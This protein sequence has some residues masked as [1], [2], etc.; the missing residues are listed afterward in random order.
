MNDLRLSVVVPVLQRGRG[1]RRRSSTGS[2][3]ASPCRA[4]CWRSTT[5]PTTRRSPSS[6]SAPATTRAWCPPSTPTARARRCA[7]RYGIDHAE[8]DDRRGH[9]GRRQRRPPAGRGP[10]PPGRAGR[11]GRRRVALRQGRPAGRRPVAEADHVPRRRA[12]P[13]LVRPGRHPRRDQLVQG[14]RPRLRA[15]RWAS[16]PTPASSSGSRWWP[17]PG[18]TACRWPSCRRSGSTARSAPSNFQVWSW[19]PR[20]LRWYRYAFGPRL[21]MKVLVSGSSGF[22]GGYVVQELLVA[23][24][25]GGRHRRPLQVRQGRQVLRRRPRL[26]AGRGRRPR[27]RADDRAA[28]RLRPLHRRRG[29][30]R[31]DLVL[32]RLRL[33]PARQQRADHGR[34]VR[35]R[36]QGRRGAGGSRRSPT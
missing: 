7:L 2:S 1:D 3:T 8:A 33:R 9:D 30:D 20:Y 10:G 23:R 14:L 35:R 19:L 25:R 32:P 34:V 4:R 27:R 24:P 16:S 5:R 31:R 36:D 28:R 13:L 15:A 21:S 12:L 18:G 29:D 22:I 26:P 17:R 11:R 6:R